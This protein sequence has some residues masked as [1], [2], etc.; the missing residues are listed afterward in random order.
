MVKFEFY[1][2]QVQEQYKWRQDL[3]THLSFVCD[4][5]IQKPK[6]KLHKGVIVVKGSFADDSDLTV[7]DIIDDLES[8][9]SNWK[10]TTERPASESPKETTQKKRPKDVD[11]GTRL[12]NERQERI[13]AANKRKRKAPR[14]KQKQLNSDE[15]VDVLTKLVTDNAQ[16]YMHFAHLANAFMNATDQSWNKTYKKQYGKLLTFI[17]S[18]SDTFL[19]VEAP[20]KDPQLKQVWMKRLYEAKQ[21]EERRRLDQ[22]SEIDTSRKVRSPRRRKK[23][24]SSGPSMLSWYVVVPSFITTTL[25]LLYLLDGGRWKCES[26]QSRIEDYPWLGARMDSLQAAYNNQ[27]NIQKVSRLINSSIK[28]VITQVLP[29]SWLKYCVS[30]TSTETIR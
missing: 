26:I 10:G 3:L 17:Q 18:H 28:P 25:I 1:V 29:E 4:G 15:L 19:I 27:P 20:D 13:A 11:I 5:R 14:K 24:A 12:E 22:R 21:E 30:N 16:V 2:T 7:E 23:R 8:Y 9:S 6:V